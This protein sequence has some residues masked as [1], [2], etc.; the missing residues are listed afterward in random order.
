MSL[1]KNIGIGKNT[2]YNPFNHYKGDGEEW[3]K[4]M[5]ELNIFPKEMAYKKL[6]WKL[7]HTFGTLDMLII[8]VAWGEN[9]TSMYVHTDEKYIEVNSSAIGLAI[10]GYMKKMNPD[11]HYMKIDKHESVY[12]RYES[13]K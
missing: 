5:L 13:C 1:V 10:A 7:E 11:V 2:F 8:H 9:M 3:F 4:E 6:E 12:I